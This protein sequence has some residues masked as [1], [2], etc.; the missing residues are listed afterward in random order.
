[1]SKI[2][3]IEEVAEQ[4]YVYDAA[5]DYPHA[6]TTNGL[7]SHNCVLLVDEIDKGLGGIAGGGSDSGVSMRVLGSFLTWLN[8]TTAPVFCVVTANNVTG[9]PPELLRRGRFD[10]IFSTSMPTP[11]ERK[12]VFS[13]HLRKRGHSLDEFDEE[14][15]EQIIAASE[16]YIPAE[17]E[18]S[19]KDAKVDA[20][21]EDTNLEAKHILKALKDMV[22]LSKSFAAQIDAMNKWAA[23]NATPVSLSDRQRR[24]RAASSK[25]R[26]RISTRR[27]SN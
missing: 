14:S 6:Y 4:E 11:S 1:M 25:N 16:G 8:D 9:L 2:T 26:S 10:A 21:Y 15:L 7:V 12:E 18:A 22:P 27:R 20:F 3:C 17:L 24:E 19:V 13:I 5:C 23:D